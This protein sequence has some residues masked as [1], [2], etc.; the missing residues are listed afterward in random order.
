MGAARKWEANETRFF[1]SLAV[2]VAQHVAELDAPLGADIKRGALTALGAHGGPEALGALQR[3]LADPDPGL[4]Q[5]A[6]DALERAMSSSPR[7]AGYDRN[8]PCAC[9]SG[10]KWKHCCAR[11]QVAWQDT[12]RT[13]RAT[14]SGSGRSR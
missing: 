11:G 14:I 4:E 2:D 7:G 1:L 9:G 6:L 3:Y 5:A 8:S 10:E 12:R 13:D